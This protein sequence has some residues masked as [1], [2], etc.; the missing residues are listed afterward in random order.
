MGKTL[1]IAIDFDDTFT[2]DPE[3]FSQFICDAQ[4]LG[5]YVV[6]VTA[7]RDTDENRQHISECFAEYGVDIPIIFSNLGS[8]LYTVEKRGLKVDIWIDDAPYAIVNGM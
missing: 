3:L 4:G 1:T 8:K 6:C 2:A 7:R 5:H